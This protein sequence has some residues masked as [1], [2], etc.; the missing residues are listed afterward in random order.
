VCWGLY[1]FS[2]KLKL[3]T[4]LRQQNVCGHG[5]GGGGC[6]TALS[7]QCLWCFS[8]KNMNYVLPAKLAAMTQDGP[9]GRGGGGAVVCDNDLWAA[10]VQ[11]VRSF[12]LFQYLTI[13]ICA[14]F[15]N[16]WDVVGPG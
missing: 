16:A 4:T 10:M 3:C 9:R 1:H 14:G 6:Q 5:G 8:A 15:S 11:R 7:V 12:I 2:I 13:K